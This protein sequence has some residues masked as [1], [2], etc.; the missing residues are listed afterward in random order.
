M[1]PRIQILRELIENQIEVVAA[2]ICEGNSALE[3]ELRLE[4][5]TRELVI[6]ESGQRVFTDQSIAERLWGLQSA[7]RM[8]QPFTLKQPRSN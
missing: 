4:W 7:S 5:L 6:E 8:P 2:A 3:A 1:E